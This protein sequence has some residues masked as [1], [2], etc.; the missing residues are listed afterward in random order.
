MWRAQLGIAYAVQVELH[1]LGVE[2]GAVV[3]LHALAQG[4]G[5]LPTIIGADPGQR[6]VGDDLLAVLPLPVHQAVEQV[7]QHV[8]RRH[9]ARYRGV[10][11]VD[12]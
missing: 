2:V 9:A 8:V 6:Q 10:E 1:R 5:P 11:C 3:K 4:E 7:V 12:V